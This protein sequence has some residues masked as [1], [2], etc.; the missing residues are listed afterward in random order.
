MLVYEGPIVQVMMRTEGLFFLLYNRWFHYGSFQINFFLFRNILTPLEQHIKIILLEVFNKYIY[1]YA[2]INDSLECSTWARC[3]C[4]LRTPRFR[5]K[6]VQFVYSQK[7]ISILPY[8]IV[9]PLSSLTVYIYVYKLSEQSPL[10]QI[11]HLLPPAG[12]NFIHD[13]TWLSKSSLLTQQTENSL[14]DFPLERGKKSTIL[15]GKL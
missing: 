10:H 6:V 8:A 15:F 3:I 12:P 11:A 13:Y 2:I 14:E 5:S 1:I 9:L 4:K 7:K